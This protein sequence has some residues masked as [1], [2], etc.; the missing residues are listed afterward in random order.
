ML[1]CDAVG[2]AAGRRMANRKVTLLASIE[3]DSRRVKKYM[4]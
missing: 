3:R 1:L 4:V 2:N